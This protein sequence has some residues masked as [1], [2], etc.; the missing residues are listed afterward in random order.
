MKHFWVLFLIF[1]NALAQQ[2]GIVVDE[3]NN[4]IPYVNIWVENK[5]KG[6]T[7]DEKGF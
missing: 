1:G 2:K 3:Q 7:T 6:T 4:P 5:E